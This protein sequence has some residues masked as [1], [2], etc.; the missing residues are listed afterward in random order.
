VSAH[1]TLTIERR[2][3]SPPERVFDAFTSEE[4]MRR[5]WHAG[6]DWETPEARVDL[7]IGGE[8]RVVM[9]NPHKDVKYGGGGV[10]TEIEPPSRLAFT[11]IWDDD[12]DQVEQ[13]IVID[14]EEDEGA[15]NVRFTH[16][17]LWNDEALR[18]HERGWNL[19]FDNLERVF[20]QLDP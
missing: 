1:P 16:E 3:G 10:Y 8:V 11:W 5:W 14:F 15:T 13:L 7:R 6:S 9:R 17:N 19:T 4:V 20:A 12:R 18:D 2:F